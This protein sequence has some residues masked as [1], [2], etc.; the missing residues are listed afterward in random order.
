[1]ASTTS[2]NKPCRCCEGTGRESDDVKLGRTLSGL[3]LRAGLSLR[4]VAH[5][6][7]ISHSF[8][9]QL[10]H[11]TRRWH[12]SKNWEEAYRWELQSEIQVRKDSQ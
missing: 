9:S 2:G 10:E 6:M 4:S 11:G 5:Q 8:L 12:G 7:G 3:R 1:M